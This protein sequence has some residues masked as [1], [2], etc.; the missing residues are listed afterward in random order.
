MDLQN[1]TLNMTRESNNTYFNLVREMAY[2]QRLNQQQPAQLMAQQPM[3]H[4]AQQP[5]PSY[6]SQ[7][8]Q[9]V[10]TEPNVSALQ[11]SNLGPGNWA[12]RN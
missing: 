12:A 7:T 1:F 4:Y 8:Q 11:N 2:S 10:L 3:F 9:T 5:V 6:A